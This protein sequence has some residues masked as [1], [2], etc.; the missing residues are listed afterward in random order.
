MLNKFSAYLHKIA[1]LQNTLIFLLLFFLTVSLVFPFIGGLLGLPEELESAD[2]TY[3]YSANDLYEIIETYDE[4]S[5][6]ASAIFHFTAD[7]IFPLVYLFSFGT[8]ISLT[9][10]RGFPNTDWL[11]RANLVPFWLL[12]FDLLENSGLAFL[13][14]RYPQQ[15]MGLARLTSFISAIKWCLSGLTVLLVAI[16]LLGMLYRAFSKS[17]PV[18]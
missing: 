18:T 1:T 2:T 14:L 8:L 16:G 6:R 11:R 3:F 17:S 13:F 15:H 4:P 7:L 12:I 5:R 9:L 10:S